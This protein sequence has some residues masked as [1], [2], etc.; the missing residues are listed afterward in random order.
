MLPQHIPTDHKHRA[1]QDLLESAVRA[2]STSTGS[3]ADLAAALS[4]SERHLRNLFTAGIGVSPKH[5]ARITRIRQVLAAAGNTPWSDLALTAG[6]Y[7]QS[8]MTAD[9]RAIM[10][11][12]PPPSSRAATPPPPAAPR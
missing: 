9:F 4:V 6:F 10:G 5:F 3:I 8:H 7:D 2:L 11:V 1:R 12:P